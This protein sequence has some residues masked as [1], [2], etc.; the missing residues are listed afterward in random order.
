[1][2]LLDAEAKAMSVCKSDHN[3]RCYKQYVT[4]KYVIFILEYCNNESLFDEIQKRKK[5]P[6]A[7]AK[8]ILKQLIIAFAVKYTLFRKC[9]RTTLSIET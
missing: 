9:I 7:E 2:K 8:R 6:E 4:K 3:V 1:M 5:I